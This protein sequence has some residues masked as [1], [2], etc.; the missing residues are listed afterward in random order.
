MAL[1]VLRHRLIMNSD[2]ELSQTPL[3]VIAEILQSITPP[4]SDTDH[5][6][7]VE[8]AVGDGGTK[9]IRKR[10]DRSY[11]SGTAVVAC[12]GVA[13]PLDCAEVVERPRHGHD[14]AEALVIAVATVNGLS[15]P[16]EPHREHGLPPDDLR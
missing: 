13:V 14:A 2:A 11:G 9:P 1:P 7:D 6:V 10:P 5:S 16:V 15:G 3:A 4:G 8:T 12:S